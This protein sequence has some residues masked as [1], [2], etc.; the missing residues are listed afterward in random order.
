MR[1]HIY[2]NILEKK[3]DTIGIDELFGASLTANHGQFVTKQPTL[4]DIA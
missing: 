1:T 3:D 4:H 2:W